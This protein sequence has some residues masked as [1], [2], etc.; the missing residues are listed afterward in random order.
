MPF[1]E[2]DPN[3]NR[4]GRPKG[5]LN[6]STIFKNK[7]FDIISSRER[8]LEVQDILELAKLGAKFVPKSIEVKGEMEHT[9]FIDNMVKQAEQVQKEENG[10]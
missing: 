9:G 10:D 6:K 5:S 7:I 2:N 3:I 4:E 1:K 8:E